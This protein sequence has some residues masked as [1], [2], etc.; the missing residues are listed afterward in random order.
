[1]RSRS[2]TPLSNP[3]TMDS[4]RHLATDPGCE[5]SGIG[6]VS[7]STSAARAGGAGNPLAALADA[8]LASGRGKAGGAA[9]DLGGG[10][11]PPPHPPGAGL[12]AAWEADRARARARAWAAQ[13]HPGK[14]DERGVCACSFFNGPPLVCRTRRSHLLLGRARGSVFA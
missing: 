1:M 6:S 12:A 7:S 5:Q 11:A 9:P 14:R 13:C 2:H 10:A 3:H 8:V 4:L